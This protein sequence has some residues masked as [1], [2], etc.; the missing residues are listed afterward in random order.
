[1]HSVFFVILFL[2]EF[3]M[4]KMFATYRLAGLTKLFLNTFCRFLIK[5]SKAQIIYE[6]TNT[7]ES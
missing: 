5:N 1:M 6:L 3:S 2:A 4:L 7:F